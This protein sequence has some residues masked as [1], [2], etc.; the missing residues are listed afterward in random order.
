MPFFIPDLEPNGASPVGNSYSSLYANCPKKF[1]N[2]F[3][4]PV[5][6]VDGE[7][8][9]VVARG[10]KTRQTK[11]PFL[12]GSIFHEGLAA[13]YISGCRDGEDTGQ[14]NLEAALAA[15]EVH[16]NARKHEYSD[17]EIATADWA[18]N[19]QMLVSYVDRYGPESSVPDYPDIRVVCDGEGKP[20]VERE[21]QVDLGFQDYIYTMRADLVISHR[22]FVKIMEHKTSVA[23]WVRQRLS[24]S[25]WD[26]QMT[27]Q[28]WILDT[29]FP[30]EALAGVLVNVVVKNRSL[31]STFDIAER[32]TT[33]RTAQQLD[34]FRLNTLDILHEINKR[35][36]KFEETLKRSGDVEYAAQL[37]F[38]DHGTRTGCCTAYNSLCEYADLCKAPG[39]EKSTLANYKP[40][41]SE[42]LVELKEW[43]G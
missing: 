43:T 31:K 25:H 10:I 29:L 18:M 27:G 7:G 41:T 17:Q 11:L 12:S 19:K 39:R 4:R 15:A 40:R 6:Y 34:N 21:F 9:L 32:E 24:T 30:G 20:L 33:T 2:T 5:E 26:S 1:F 23:S 13:W 37:W 42:E 35:L 38:P 28:C 14:Y 22:G 16:F 36:E 8:N 3:L